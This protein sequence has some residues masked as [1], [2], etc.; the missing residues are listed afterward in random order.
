M[1]SSNSQLSNFKYSYSSSYPSFK[2]DDKKS[3]K[4]NPID[5]NKT[6]NTPQPIDEEEQQDSQ[7]QTPI[8][9]DVPNP[10]THNNPSDKWDPNH[11]IRPIHD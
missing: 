1:F 4:P 11:P 8:L 5:E 9:E 2:E 7:N 6:P 10:Y 3:N